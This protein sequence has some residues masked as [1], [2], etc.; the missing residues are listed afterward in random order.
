MV[1]LILANSLILK[2]MLGYQNTSEMTHF[3]KNNDMI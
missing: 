1:R 2:K 3:I